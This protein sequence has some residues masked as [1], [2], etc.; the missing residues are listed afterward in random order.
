[1]WLEYLKAQRRPIHLVCA[2][3]EGHISLEDSLLA[4]ALIAKL[5]FQ[6]ESAELGNDSARIAR[7]FWLATEDSPYRN[8]GIEQS[9]GSRRTWLPGPL[10]QFLRQGRGG[11]NVLR[12]G[13]GPDID[14]ATHVDR[15]DLVAQ[16]QRDPVR[17]VTADE[18]AGSV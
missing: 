3:T 16:V 5:T 14:D 2:G 10:A 6:I 13:L 9:S 11:Q 4:G 7:G 12:I 1:L 15:F 17:I 18:I 8:N